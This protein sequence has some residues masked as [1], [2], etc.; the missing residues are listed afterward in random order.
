[1]KKIIIILISLLVVLS[2]CSSKLTN[3]E[4]MEKV[5]EKLENINTYKYEMKTNS[6]SDMTIFGQEVKVISEAIAKGKV[7]NENSNMKIETITKS[8][9]DG[10][11]TETTEIKYTI[12]GINYFKSGGKWYKMKVEAD[13]KI[14]KTENQL[15]Q[16]K[17]YM[18]SGD[19]QILSKEDISDDIKNYLDSK[20]YYVVKINVDVKKLSETALQDN[21]A[22]IENSEI[23]STDVIKSSSVIYW[24]NKKTFNIEKAKIDMVIDMDIELMKIASDTSIE[25]EFKD[26]NEDVEII[27]PD[28]AKDARDYE[29]VLKEMTEGLGDM[30]GNLAD[31]MENDDIDTGRNTN[32]GGTT[33][34]STECENEMDEWEIKYCYWDLAVQEKDVEFCKKSIG[35][36]FNCMLGVD[37][38]KPIDLNK[39]IEVCEN[40]EID[41]KR[42][43]CFDQVAKLKK[44]LELCNRSEFPISCLRKVDE[45]KDYNILELTTFCEGYDDQVEKEDCFYDIAMHRN[46]A[47]LCDKITDKEWNKFCLEDLA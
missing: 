32:S 3:E 30:F 12:N 16:I 23:D 7:D 31:K 36:E 5:L 29:E 8:E 26:I 35:T 14:K 10:T 6:D 28:E 43:D 37:K 9:S 1:M 46:D 13:S 38:V 21:Q 17:E 44:N 39:M 15:E 20:L 4:I 24:I 45:K 22:L 19:I 34:S 47:S 27:L 18:E 33:I 2:A 40:I 42:M 25:I 41:W 11:K